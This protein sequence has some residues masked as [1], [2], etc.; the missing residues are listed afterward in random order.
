MVDVRVKIET[1]FIGLDADQVF[2]HEN[3]G[4]VVKLADG[5]ILEP[6]VIF[7]ELTP[8]L[9]HDKSFYA[10]R[11]FDLDE[12]SSKTEIDLGE[13]QRDGSFVRQND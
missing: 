3:M 5:R 13:E 2:D 4:P 10:E 11:V 6:E 9:E 8:D 7:N 12:T 1:V